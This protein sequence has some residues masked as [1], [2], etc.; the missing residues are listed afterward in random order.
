[1]PRGKPRNRQ[2]TGQATGQGDE[3]LS[4]G[5]I[6]PVAPQEL[7]M[8]SSTPVGALSLGQLQ[9]MIASTVH[10]AIASHLHGMG[11]SRM[12]GCPRPDE[13]EEHELGATMAATVL[14]D[15]TPPHTPP[16]RSASR[17][18]GFATSKMQLLFCLC[19]LF[20]VVAF[21]TTLST[22]ASLWETGLPPVNSTTFGR[23]VSIRR[24]LL[25]H[26]AAIS[27]ISCASS[28]NTSDTHTRGST[29]RFLG[30]FRYHRAPMRPAISTRSARTTIS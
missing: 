6:P 14:E 24:T 19:Y 9:Q 23:R 5:P 4:R 20:V 8:G 22:R 15:T 27:A 28:K 11:A 13:D 7:W 25:S 30:T 18:A 1:M 12:S 16:V 29:H 2:Q 3:D 17:P 10:S 26:S 21:T